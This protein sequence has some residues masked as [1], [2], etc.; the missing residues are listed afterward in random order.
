M[1]KLLIPK[2]A[3]ER[4]EAEWWYAHAEV[5][6]ANLLEAMRNGTAGRD[7]LKRLADQRAAKN[8]APAKSN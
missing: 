6:Q 7:I 4:E 8:P 5:V 2:F 3:S 1:K